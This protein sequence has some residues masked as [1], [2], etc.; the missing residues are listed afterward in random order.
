MRC[1]NEENYVNELKYILPAGVRLRYP[2][3]YVLIAM[4]VEMEVFKMKQTSSPSAIPQ[5]SN[6][7]TR[8]PFSRFCRRIRPIDARQNSLIKLSTSRR[9]VEKS[10]QDWIVAS[11][12]NSHRLN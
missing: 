2:S 12:L 4:E 6:N 10:W 7:N 1:N 5:N 3:S 9:V 8:S 11:G